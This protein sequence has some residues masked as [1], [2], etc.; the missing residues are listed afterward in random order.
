MH[1]FKM[2]STKFLQLKFIPFMKK[3]LSLF[4]Q[5]STIGHPSDAEFLAHFNSHRRQRS[6]D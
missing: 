5:L 3:I 6:I 2:I 1:E 4:F